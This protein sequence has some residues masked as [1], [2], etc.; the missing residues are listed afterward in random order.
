VSKTLREKRQTKLSYHLCMGSSWSMAIANRLHITVEAEL[1]ER[2]P[3]MCPYC[4]GKPCNCG[5]NRP[6]NRKKLAVDPRRRPSSCWG[7]Q[8]MFAEIYPQ[9]LGKAA[10]HTA[11]EG[12]EVVIALKNYLGTHAVQV[13]K[14]AIL[15]LM[16]LFSVLLAVATN[17]GL[18]LA[19]EMEKHF[20]KGCPGCSET[21]CDCTY[22][23]RIEG[24][25]QKVKEAR[26][27]RKQHLGRR[28]IAKRTRR[29]A[30]ISQTA[31]RRARRLS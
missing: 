11:E 10:T 1:W 28:K 17:A 24:L 26:V 12:I 30:S 25:E 29:V 16:D 27:A 5:G 19:T 3:N 20:K 7:Y 31:R 6:K 2:F 9:S 15:E 14:H 8:A 21:P 23:D 18:D 13:R 22:S 4:S